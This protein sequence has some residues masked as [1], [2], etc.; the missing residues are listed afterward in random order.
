MHLS[1][2]AQY[3]LATFMYVQCLK[4][5]HF[6]KIEIKK[7]SSIFKH[8]KLHFES[9]YDEFRSTREHKTFAMEQTYHYFWAFVKVGFT[10]LS[11]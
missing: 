7:I 10:I 2:F 8:A 4:S 1:P 6:Q 9:E 5:S 11:M 3:F